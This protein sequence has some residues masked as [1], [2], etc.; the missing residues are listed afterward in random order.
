MTIA[1]YVHSRSARLVL[2]LPRPSVFTHSP[3]ASR[4]LRASS[5]PSSH[6]G[7]FSI[8]QRD[9]RASL[10]TGIFVYLSCKLH[11]IL[12]TARAKQTLFFRPHSSLHYVFVC[13]F[14]PRHVLLREQ[15]GR[16]DQKAT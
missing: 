4:N 2:V 14:M 10:F 13:R 1:L 12:M 16:L 3:A 8:S 7:I 15:V 11:T 5:I 6:A 9:N